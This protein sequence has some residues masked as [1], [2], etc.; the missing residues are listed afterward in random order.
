MNAGA[1]PKGKMFD[2]TIAELSVL[3]LA[4]ETHAAVLELAQIVDLQESF[5][6]RE[7]ACRK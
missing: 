3:R 4:F 2:C 1:A 6:E 5:V 7:S